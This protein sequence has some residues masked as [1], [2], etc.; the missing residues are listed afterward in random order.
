VI[1]LYADKYAWA[2]GDIVISGRSAAFKSA[3]PV[4]YD[5]DGNVIPLSKRFDQE[6]TSI[7][8]QEGD[9]N[10]D[11]FEDDDSYSPTDNDA[12]PG[13]I[14]LEMRVD[15]DGNPI[16][17]PQGKP[18]VRTIGYDL[19]T[20]PM[21]TTFQGSPEDTTKPD[22]TKLH[23]TVTGPSRER[24]SAAIDSGAVDLVVGRLVEETQ[25][26]LRNPAVAA[27]KGWYSRMRVKLLAAFG[28]EDA[29]M[30][31]H[32]LA[33]PAPK[34]PSRTTSSTPWTSCAVSSAGSSTGTSVS[35]RKW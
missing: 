5:A 12:D 32:L 28:P 20:A 17:N 19:L 24:L 4:T 35:T 1:K 11:Q 2:S 30:F 3:E 27:G 15:E 31:S 18:R 7:L 22:T 14:P 29:R 16:L 26:M 10:E 33:P 21:V 23:Y 8:Y 9:I 25:R 34:P 6:N 13:A